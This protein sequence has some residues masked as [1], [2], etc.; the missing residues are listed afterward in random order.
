[1]NLTEVPEAIALLS[2]ASASRLS[3]DNGFDSLTVG[4]RTL[5]SQADE[6]YRSLLT[7][8]TDPTKDGPRLFSFK[9]VDPSFWDKPKWIAQKFRLTLWC[10]HSRLPLTVLN[11]DDTSGVYEIELTRDWI[12]R[13]SPILRELHALLK[14]QDP[15]HSFGGLERIQNKRPEF[16]WIHP[17]F[18]KEY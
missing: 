13:A 9:P 1:M 15:G 18:L 2:P 6:Q 11:D 5:L 4:Q 3:V 8:L 10:E 12:K 14:A 17:Q 7:I 16:L